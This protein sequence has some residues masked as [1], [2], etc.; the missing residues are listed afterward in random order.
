[1]AV[2]RSAAYRSQTA[3]FGESPAHADA[4]STTSAA[5]LGKLRS[6]EKRA[7]TP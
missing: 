4:K 2:E 6:A 5:R 3:R 1:M 7:K